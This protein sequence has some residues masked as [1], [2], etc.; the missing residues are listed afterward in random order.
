MP[1]VGGTSIPGVVLMGS[2]GSISGSLSV[3]PTLS[4]ANGASLSPGVDLATNHLTA[5]QIPAA[6]TAAALTFQG[7]WDGNTYGNVYDGVTGAE[8]TI[9]SAIVLANAMIVL[10]P[11]K[12]R[13]LRFIKVRSGTQAAP[14]NQAAQRDLK[15]TV[16]GR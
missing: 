11:V 10:D 16:V 9:A 13:G 15:L 6:W 7:S 5:I 1:Q 12:F 2:D 4:I 3:M 14:V 8:L